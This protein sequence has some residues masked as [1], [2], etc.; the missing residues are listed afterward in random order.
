MQIHANS[1]FLEST[2]NHLDIS[3]LFIR[4]GITNESIDRYTASAIEW[5][6][7]NALPTDISASTMST[8]LSNLP[9]FAMI[10]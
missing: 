2:R 4:L 1:L 5:R 3:E 9:V 6:H 8:S 10:D 7:G